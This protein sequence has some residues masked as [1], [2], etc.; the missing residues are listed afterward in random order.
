MS[1]GD[2]IFRQLRRRA[3][4]MFARLRPPPAVFVYGPHYECS[5]PGSCNDEVR[6]ERV[7]TALAAEGLVTFEQVR[8]PALAT[9]HAIRRVHDDAYLDACQRPEV[10]T[11]IL[12]GLAVSEVDAGRI[13]DLQRAMTG[14][15]MLATD[16][17]LGTGK[18][19]INLGG[20]FH[21]AQ[22]D[23]GRGFCVFH[24]VAVAIA[25]QRALGFHER[26][27]VVDLDQHDGDGTRALF[28]EDPTVFTL[29]I[30][31]H[32]WGDT[33]AVASTSVAL[34]D[35]VSDALYL[36]TV[37][38][39]LAEALRAHRPR[40][41]YFLAGVDPAEGDRIGVWQISAQGMLERDIAVF[42][43]LR[44]LAPDA[45]VVVCLAGG[46]GPTAWQHSARSFAW[47]QSGH[48]GFEP[49][50][51]DELSLM[52]A[53]HYAA[54]LKPAEL[55]GETDDLGLTLEDL[56]PSLAAQAR[57]P[58]FLGYYSRQGLELALERHGLLGRVR[59]KGFEPTVEF[60]L[61]D[62]QRHILKIFGDPDRRELLLELV[63]RRDRRTIP[64]YE[65]LAIDWLLLQNPRER[66]T[67]E[68]PALPGQAHP[69]LGLFDETVALLIIA[70]ERVGLAGL[71][72]TPSQ[73][74][75]AVQW[76][77]RL[78]FVDPRAAARMRAIREA[79]PGLSLP[80]AA[81]ALA[82]GRVVD[83]R[84]GETCSYEPAPMVFPLSD[85]LKAELDPEG[86]LRAVDEAA[87]DF[88][89][90]LRPA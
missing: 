76:Q 41:V 53:R 60:N 63:V 62:P 56:V 85:E 90:R 26:V 15:T 19:A 44:E 25:E 61:T 68:R 57:E 83:E 20:G 64:G 89:F 23:R 70:C 28:A 39:H 32:H 49:P 30:H 50:D 22:R 14:G 34:G 77:K 78:R 8:R 17:A 1:T 45:A 18:I 3:N 36:E 38:L 86:Y 27:L 79:M 35:V 59:A 84:T 5:W 47:L 75:L 9:Y 52:R 66:F 51:N 67:P 6:G 74:H 10:M 73:Y 4:Q 40:L 21:H 7:L 55:T 54:L 33:D 11:D 71:V 69:G 13:L 31:N 88:R 65:L 37:Q 12:G 43:L 87:D 72:V 46:Y 24:D 81:R 16:I 2:R 80:D 48:R 29:S 42:E 82:A 58:R